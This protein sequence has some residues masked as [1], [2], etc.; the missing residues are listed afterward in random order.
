MAQFQIWDGLITHV[1]VNNGLVR[2][3]NPF[4]ASLVTGGDF[5]LLKI[6]GAFLCVPILWVIYKYLPKFTTVAAS[7]LVVFYAAVIS[8]NFL[9]FF[10]IV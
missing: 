4:I 10:S 9:V 8:W 6:V 2:E 5:L 7:G 1:F 3:G